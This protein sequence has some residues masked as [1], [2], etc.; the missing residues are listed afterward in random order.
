MRK[1]STRGPD[2]EEPGKRQCDYLANSG[3][4]PAGIFRNAQTAF[5]IAQKPRNYFLQRWLPGWA[6]H[7]MRL[8]DGFFGGESIGLIVIRRVAGVSPVPHFPDF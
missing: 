2:T 7:P 6:G 8:I 3:G 4:V 5:Q 1:W